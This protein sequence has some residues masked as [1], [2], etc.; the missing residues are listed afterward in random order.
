MA[1]GGGSPRWGPRGGGSQG[2]G[3]L[4]CLKVAT[5]TPQQQITTASKV[6][7]LTLKSRPFAPPLG[8]ARSF[9]TVG[10]GLLGSATLRLTCQSVTPGIT[11]HPSTQYHPTPPCPHLNQC[12]ALIAKKEEVGVVEAV[13]HPVDLFLGKLGV[14]EPRVEICLT[15]VT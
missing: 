14:L 4:P 2:G 13:L 15:V 12:L 9:R 5:H 1:Q 3:C 11:W 8:L 7:E 6:W 10:G